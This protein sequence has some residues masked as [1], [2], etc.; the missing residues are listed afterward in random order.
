[1][2][3]SRVD[4]NL[5]VGDTFRVG[6]RRFVLRAELS[7]EILG[8]NEKAIR[9]DVFRGKEHTNS[10]FFNRCRGVLAIAVVNHGNDRIPES[11]FFSKG[12]SGLFSSEDASCD[13]HEIDTGAAAST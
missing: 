12:S 13:R 9:I 4:D 11:L 6:E 1:M 3:V 10:F 2:A 5:S 7:F 8:R